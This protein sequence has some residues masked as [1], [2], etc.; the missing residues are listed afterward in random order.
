MHGQG[1][2]QDEYLPVTRTELLEMQ[3]VYA[4]KPATPLQTLV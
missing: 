4:P 2:G 3:A 1:A